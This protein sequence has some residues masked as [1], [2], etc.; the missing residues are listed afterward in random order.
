VIPAFIDSG[1][2]FMRIFIALFQVRCSVALEAPA[3]AT[4]VAASD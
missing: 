3:E 1:D 4:R 2:G